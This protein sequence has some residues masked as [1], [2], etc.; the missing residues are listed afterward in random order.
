MA[1]MAKARYSSSSFSDEKA[2]LSVLKVWRAQ[3]FLHARMR[4]DQQLLQG[5]QGLLLEE[6][7][8]RLNSEPGPRL[9]VDGLWF[10]RPFGG[11][12]ARVWQQVLKCWL[13]PGLLTEFAPVALIERDSQLALTDA[14]TAL[15]GIHV[16]PLDSAAVRTLAAENTSLARNWGADVFCSSWISTCGIETST[17]SELALVHD[18]LPERF[19]SRQKELLLVRR[20]WWQ[21]A[22]AH[23]A[24]SRATAAD[25]ERMLKVPKGSVSWCHMAPDAVF[26]TTVA[27]AEAQGLWTRLAKQVG[28]QM[29]FV[30]LPA[31]S[32]IG[33]YKNPQL[34]AEALAAPAL[35]PLQL[36]LCGIA[37][38][39]RCQELE[40]RFP[41]LAGR[42]VSAG[43]SDFELVLVYSHALA[44]VIPSLI[45]GFG[46][47]V[48]EAL[49]AGGTVLA[50]DSRGLQEAGGEAALRFDPQR[51]E[52]LACL[53]EMLMNASS[54]DILQLTLSRR[55]QQRLDRLNPDLFGLALL[56][57]ARE[58]CR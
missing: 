47:P 36:V 16:D 17:C 43:F 15:E 30:L 54:E 24:V 11:G 48:V 18:C 5:H 41:H 1:L 46:L 26:S 35:R 14:F 10:S 9:L 2:A 49:A 13:L 53:L 39:Q 21:G 55:R 7:S 37:A 19:S 34:V 38:E 44:V 25:L 12:I 28:M 58:M 52:E 57:M 27:N 31:T 3:G 6:L 40:E 32:A 42:L 45:E 33:S 8:A 22:A 4:L 20:R 29:P 51:P 50:A 23:L 56:A